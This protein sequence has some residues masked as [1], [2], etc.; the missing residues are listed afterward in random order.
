ME[1]A[2]SIMQKKALAQKTPAAPPVSDD[3]TESD[4]MAIQDPSSTNQTLP[5]VSNMPVGFE[6]QLQDAVQQ[7]ALK[8]KEIGALQQ[9]GI[10]QLKQYQQDYSQLPI[11]TDYSPMAALVDSINQNSNKQTNF[12]QTFQNQAQRQETP[13]GRIAN[14]AGLQK[15]VL[16]QQM[17]LGKED[18]G[19]LKDQLDFYK[20]QQLAKA[21][22]IKEAA[23]AAQA[24]R[25]ELRADLSERNQKRADDRLE[26]ALKNSNNNNKTALQADRLDQNNHTRIITKLGQDKMLGQRLTQVNNLDN[27]T[28]AFQQGTATPQQFAELQQAVRS[29]MGLK[30]SSGVGEREEVYL[31]S[32][33]INSA[34]VKQFITGK[35]QDI[36][37][38]TDP[39]MINHIL[40]LVTIEKN[41]VKKQADQ[42]IKALVAGHES[43]Y[44]RNPIL[45]DD[46]DSAV[47][48]V[49]QQFGE[50]SAQKQQD[51]QYNDGDI[52]DHG[53]TKYK[54]QDGV[55]SEVSE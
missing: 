29:N 5:P 38:F 12:A 28:S 44:E 36:S 20:A 3:S 50:D 45:K 39:S 9:G 19:G 32:L 35:P 34:V 21:Q 41:N 16:G 43:M 8:R 23:Q 27:A 52:V 49:G 10:D 37:K 14:M 1:S 18:L 31:K 46:L 47:Q 54:L 48:A 11:Q 55:W 33:G 22:N 26:I 2:W 4:L 51:S 15:D 6:Q 25:D 30:G 17:A 13:Q 7:Q 40:N 42:R 53:G 24:K